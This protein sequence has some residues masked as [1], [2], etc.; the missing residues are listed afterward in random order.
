MPGANRSKHPRC[1]PHQCINDISCKCRGVTY[2]KSASTCN[3]EFLHSFNVVFFFEFH[4][5][6]GL[7]FYQRMPHHAF[8]LEMPTVIQQSSMFT[9]SPNNQPAFTVSAR[10]QLSMHAR[11][12]CWSRPLWWSG[13]LWSKPSQ[14]SGPLLRP[15]WLG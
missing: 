3:V 10:P 8:L 1:V 11:C 15:P 2:T 14:S 5:S 9:C 6:F 7:Q 4:T 13:M 12:G